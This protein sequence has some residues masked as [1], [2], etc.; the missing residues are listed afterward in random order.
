LGV[1]IAE[2]QLFGAAGGLSYASAPGYV[3]ADAAG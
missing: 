2:H 1:A 3:I